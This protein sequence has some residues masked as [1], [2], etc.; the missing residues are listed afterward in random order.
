MNKNNALIGFSGFV[1]STLLKQQNFKELYR[2]TNITDIQDKSFDTVV[3]AGAPAV[4]WLANKHPEKDKQ[5]IQDLI[6]HLSTI[7]CE[8]FILISTVDVF[9]NPNQATESTAVDTSGLHSYGLHR[10]EL[11]E[12]VKANFYNYLIVRLPGLVGPGLKKNV[13]Y[14][15]LNN[16][17]LEAIDSGGIFQFYPMV[18]LWSDI[19]VAIQNNCNLLHLTAEPLSVSEIAKECFNLDFDNKLS[20]NPASY[21]FQTDV[22]HLFNSEQPYQYSKKETLLAIRAYAQS[23]AKKEVE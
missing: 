1:G 22:F 14:D 7:K 19:Q 12:F 18:N 13:I 2:S 5:S 10:Y 9:Q 4:K 11:E 21:D 23:E 15:F 3:C 8:Q 17:N 6:S 16:N 20:D